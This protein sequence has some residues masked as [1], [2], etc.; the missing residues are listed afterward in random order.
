LRKQLAGVKTAGTQAEG[1]QSRESTLLK[2][3][4]AAREAAAAA[5][6]V[7]A[8]A[9]KRMVE[10]EGLRT[11]LEA[12]VAALRKNLL[13]AGSLE[14]KRALELAQYKEAASRN[15]SEAAEMKSV[16]TKLQEQ[17]KSAE[18]KGNRHSD[19]QRELSS[20][21]TKLDAEKSA[22]AQASEN[23]SHLKQQLMD[24]HGELQKSR[25]AGREIEQKTIRNEG[26]IAELRRQIK[27]SEA[28]REKLRSALRDR[29][30]QLTS[31][32][33]T[34][35]DLK[36][37]LTEAQDL[38]KAG[39][40]GRKEKKV[41]VKPVRKPQTPFETMPVTAPDSR[42]P[43]SATSA[44]DTVII[45]DTDQ[46]VFKF[47]CKCGQKLSAPRAL[48]GRQGKCPKCRHQYVIPAPAQEQT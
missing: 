12:E 5:D 39:A 13:E 46:G 32:N 11:S 8:N 7:A 30:A 1:L 43:R 36:T 41:P 34:V 44:D 18:L 3:L 31:S 17:L 38:I 47:Y 2:E 15:E 4:A 26:Q 42:T 48:V 23:Q 20:L 21:Q 19:L 16:V 6:L 33:A 14:S 45:N 25:S 9:S 28:E 22:A 29:E 24:L 40:P 10:L 35:A 37:A 27:E